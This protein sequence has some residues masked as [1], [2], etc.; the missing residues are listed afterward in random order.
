MENKLSREEVLHVAE[1]ARIKMS[2]DE[3]E[4]YQVQLKQIIDS[5]DT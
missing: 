1:L 4:K 2:E 5:G 3:I